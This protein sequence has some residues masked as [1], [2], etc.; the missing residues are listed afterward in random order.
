MIP[1]GFLALALAAVDPIFAVIP[2]SGWCENAASYFTWSEFAFVPV[3]VTN[4]FSM[5]PFDVSLPVVRIG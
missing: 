3:V 1:R 5:F 4:K 2:L